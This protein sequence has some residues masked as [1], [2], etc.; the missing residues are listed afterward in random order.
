MRIAVDYTAA[1]RQRFGV[2]RYARELIRAVLAQDAPHEYVVMTG[3]AGLG[4]RWRREKAHL[5]HLAAHPQHLRFRDLPLDDEWMARLW[6]RLR[7][8][9]PAEW[10]TGPV[11]LFYSPDFVLPPLRRGTRSMLTVHDLSFLR[12]PEAFTPALRDYLRTVVPRSVARADIVLADSEATRRDLIALLDLPPE[13]VVTLYPGLS[14]GFTPTPGPDERGRLRRRYGVGGRPYILAVGTVQP[15]KNYV[16]LMAACDALADEAELV[17]VGQRGWLADPILAEAARRPHVRMLGFVE[18]DDLAALYRQAVALAFPSLYEGFGLPPLEA[19]A[20]G[21]PVVASTASSVPEVVGDAALLL[22]PTEISAWSEAL[23]RL[24]HDEALRARLRRAGLARARTF[25][26]ER[27]AR[28]W[29][30][31][32]QSL[33]TSR[34][35]EGL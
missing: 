35:Q 10:L 19:M 30:A 28:R 33:H 34:F 15:R 1:A 25:S 9:L 26:W 11:D 12:H 17:I 14:A 6:Q 29:L 20:C 21:T 8:P 31:V 27:A 23:A 13:R 24:L 18:D 3:T 4:E 22:D 5:R 7:L 32:A 2:G 16:R